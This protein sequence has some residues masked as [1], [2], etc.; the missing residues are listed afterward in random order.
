MSNSHAR[1]MPS[2]GRAH[3]ML[4]WLT[5]AYFVIEMGVGLWAG[6]AAVISDAFHTV[7]ALGG[8]SVA[9]LHRAHAWSL[10]SD[11]HVFAGHHQLL[12]PGAPAR[13]MLE[14]AQRHLCGGRFF[15]RH[16]PARGRAPQ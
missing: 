5:G 16:S 1:H 4:A 8:V 12:A 14:E 2:R 3:A 6:S 9:K 13:K 10:T 11:R 15:L 7:S